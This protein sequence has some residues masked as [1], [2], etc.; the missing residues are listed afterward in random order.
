MC[1]TWKALIKQKRVQTG[2]I[3]SDNLQKDVDSNA[4]WWKTE[5]NSEQFSTNLY[6]EED[7]WYKHPED[8]LYLTR[9]P[10]G[11]LL[12]DKYNTLW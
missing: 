8:E 5:T 3:P 9:S 1:L 10:A 12:Y 6:L 7:V 2:P 11:L 4:C